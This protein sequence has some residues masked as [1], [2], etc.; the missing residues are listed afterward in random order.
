V[1]HTHAEAASA[2]LA[3]HIDLLKTGPDQTA[4]DVACGRGRNA[5]FLARN[6]FTVTGLERDP[7][8]IAQVRAAADAEGLPLTVASQDLE[9]EDVSLPLVSHGLVCVFYFLHRPLLPHVRNAVK[10]GG[11]VVYETFLIDAHLRWN[12]PK[13][14]AFAFEHNE[15]L[16]AFQGFRVHLYR[17]RVD[18]SARTATAQLIAQRE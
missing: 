11:F 1:A 9:A 16:D 4:L 10:P 12:S 2:L 17:E 8:A 3:D 15:L 18:E 6:G 14:R 7:E 13:R 5:L